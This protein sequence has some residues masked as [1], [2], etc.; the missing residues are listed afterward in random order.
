MFRVI[1]AYSRSLYAGT[2]LI[3]LI[4]Q[5]RPEVDPQSPVLTVRVDL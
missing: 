4:G 5:A 1:T 3:R 2:E